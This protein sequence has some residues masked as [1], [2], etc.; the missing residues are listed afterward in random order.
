MPNTVNSVT[1]DEFH[2]PIQ[3]I[4]IL[5]RRQICNDSNKQNYYERVVL[6]CYLNIIS[7]IYEKQIKEKCCINEK[8]LKQ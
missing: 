2:A 3:M 5:S 4:L 1:I 7:Y 6:I 8:P